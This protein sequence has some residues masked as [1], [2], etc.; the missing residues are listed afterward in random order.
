MGRNSQCNRQH[1]CR[2]ATASEVADATDHVLRQPTFR[3]A[4]SGPLYGQCLLRSIIGASLADVFLGGKW[5]VEAGKILLCVTQDRFVGMGDP[6]YPGNFHCWAANM[7]ER[8]A[9]L[10][11]R[12]ATVECRPAE[13]TFFDPSARHYPEYIRPEVWAR[14]S[15]WMAPGYKPQYLWKGR[16]ADVILD[17]CASTVEHDVRRFSEGACDDMI[18]CGLQY[19]FDRGM[20]AAARDVDEGLRV[21]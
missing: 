5:F 16:R 10:P 9:A 14:G 2:E 12:V 11:G 8:H 6:D 7:G 21:G 18:R 1:C 13:V 4:W 15:K 3:S 17:R 19:C 20:C